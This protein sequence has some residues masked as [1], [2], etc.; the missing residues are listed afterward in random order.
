MTADLPSNKRPTKKERI[1]ELFSEGKYSDK[2]IARIVRTT[3]ANVW[4]EKSTL[5]KSETLVRQGV[6]RRDRTLLVTSATQ[7]DYA[8]RRKSTT[9]GYQ[10]LLNITPID[11]EG[12]KKLYSSINAGKK[13]HEIIAANGFHPAVVE[14]EYLRSQKFRHDMLVKRIIAEVL[15]MKSSEKGT[16]LID[17]YNEEGYLSDDDL[18]ELLKE[19]MLTMHRLGA[20]MQRVSLGLPA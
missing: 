16:T 12:L 6:E 20:T 13:P 19:Y 17:K 7:D 14:T 9:L 8:I 10:D 15:T 1:H 4:K 3:I 18:I 2:D 11:R 5:K